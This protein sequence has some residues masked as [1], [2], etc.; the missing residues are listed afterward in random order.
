MFFI[1]NLNCGLFS[2]FY[3]NAYYGITQ[4]PKTMDFIFIMEYYESGDLGYFLTK[5]FYDIDWNDKLD[6]LNYIISGLDYI[7]GQKVIHRDLHSG[8]ILCSNSSNK[9]PVVI[10]IL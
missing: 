8:N 1:L 10:S 7:H 5:K 6:I 3:I 4:Y 9:H 2:S